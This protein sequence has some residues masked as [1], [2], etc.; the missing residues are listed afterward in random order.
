MN[1]WKTMETAPKDGSEFIVRFSLQGN[2]KAFC[3]WDKIN[4]CWMNKGSVFFPESQDCEWLSIES[5]ESKLEVAEDAL[6]EMRNWAARAGA[7]AHLTTANK[8]LATIMGK[9]VRGER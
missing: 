1:D 8:A 3:H 5:L 4:K 9:G 2:V 7:M 6:V